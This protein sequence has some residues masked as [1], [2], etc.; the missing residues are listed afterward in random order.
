MAP[1]SPAKLA[2][3][4]TGNVGASFAY[5]AVLWGLASEIV[6]VDAPAIVGRAGVERVLHLPLAADELEGLRRSAAVLRDA[7]SSLERAATSARS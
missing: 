5:A 3:V 1:G 2:V 7:L 4:G 6:L